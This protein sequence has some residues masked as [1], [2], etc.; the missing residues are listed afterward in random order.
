MMPVPEIEW[1]DD[2]EGEELWL[3]KKLL[4]QPTP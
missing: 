4:Q 1:I 3:Q 2:E